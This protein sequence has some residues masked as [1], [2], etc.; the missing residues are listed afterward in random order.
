MIIHPVKRSTQESDSCGG[1][2]EKNPGIFVEMG[3]WGLVICGRFLVVDL[4]RF[5]Y[6]SD[7]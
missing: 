1:S 5:Q 7:S 4:V 3:T 6:S 2:F